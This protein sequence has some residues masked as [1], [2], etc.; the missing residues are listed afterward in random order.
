MPSLPRVSGKTSEYK[1]TENEAKIET[2][3]KFDSGVTRAMLSCL[4]RH[5]IRRGRRRFATNITIHGYSARVERFKHTSLLHA[6]MRLLN[7]EFGWK[8]MFNALM[9]LQ[10]YYP[11]LDINT[12]ITIVEYRLLVP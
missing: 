4:L 9:G 12:P 5:T 7:Q 6:D 3:L 10:K 1:K 11:G 8:S 2:E